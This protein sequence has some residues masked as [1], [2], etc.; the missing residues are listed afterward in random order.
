MPRV[1]A[2]RPPPRLVSPL[3]PKMKKTVHLLLS[4]GLAFVIG[5]FG[6]NTWQTANYFRE[7]GREGRLQ[8]GSIYNAS[9]WAE[10]VPVKKI[11]AYTALL[12][13]KHQVLIESDQQLAEKSTVF[14]RF[15]TRDLAAS[16]NAFSI[17]P[18]VN[19]MRIR[20]AADGSPVKIEDTDAFD[21][22]VEKAMGPVG[23]DVYVRAR[24]QAEAA[25]DRAKPT[26]PF[27]IAGANDSTLEIIWNNSTVGEWVA[28]GLVVLLFKAWFLY[29][30]S[31]TW[32]APRSVTERKDFVHPSMR[33]IEPDAPAAPAA[34]LT[35]VPKPE[36]E[37][38][39]PATAPRPAPLPH[40]PP[41][42]PAPA[43]ATGEDEASAS[44]T[45]HET[46]PPMPIKSHQEPVLKLR[47]K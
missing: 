47:R 35:Y 39:L 31:L 30:L 25:P 28:Y 32:R 19:T 43:T 46:A 3:V 15:L 29:A 11:H 14:V 45:S 21:R 7:N 8:I 17:R 22:I 9:R 42:V 27:L 37:I 12:E 41:P 16:I 13:P 6:W 36:Q 18:L 2:L 23:P 5:W 10:P 20:T 24:P 1:Y 40:T 26:V 38:H 44:L 34:K 33:R 4:L